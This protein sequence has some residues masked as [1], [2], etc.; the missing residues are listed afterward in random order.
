MDRENILLID[1]DLYTRG[2]TALIAEN[3]IN[4]QTTLV[5]LLKDAREAGVL[6]D[7]KNS[8]NPDDDQLVSDSHEKLRGA[9]LIKTQADDSNENETTLYL[10]PSTP[11]FSIN[12][13]D[14]WDEYNVGIPNLRD[15]LIRLVS[16]MTTQHDFKCVI[17]DCRPGPEPLFLA[18]AGISTE[19]IL[20]TEADR[21]TFNGNRVLFEYIK[22]YYPNDPDV[23]PKVKFIINRIP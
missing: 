1:L 21:V 18:A 20:V 3:E 10:L 16:E 12:A 11:T 9:K 17:F 13:Q 6:D 8:D 4:E 22:E 19:I 5:E 7:S 23:I 14:Q 15:F 2:T